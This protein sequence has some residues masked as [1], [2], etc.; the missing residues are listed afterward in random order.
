MT[1]YCS[2]ELNFLLGIVLKF[3]KNHDLLHKDYIQLSLMYF[4]LSLF[5]NT[6]KISEYSKENT[7]RSAT[8]LKRD[9]NIGV[10]L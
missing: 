2:F 8:L 5:L 7:Y 3:D 4:A 9:S 6:K 1:R 10:F